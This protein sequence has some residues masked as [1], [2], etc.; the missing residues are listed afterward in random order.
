MGVIWG[1]SPA[2]LVP[3]GSTTLVTCQGKKGQGGSWTTWSS[4]WKDRRSKLHTRGKMFTLGVTS[5]VRHLG[6]STLVIFWGLLFL[7]ISVYLPTNIYKFEAESMR[8]GI[9]WTVS[10]SSSHLSFCSAFSSFFSV[11]PSSHFP[12]P[13]LFFPVYPSPL[14]AHHP[15][16]SHTNDFLMSLPLSPLDASELSQLYA[17]QSLR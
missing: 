9:C 8:A 4:T 15:L 10:H 16:H 3:R 17:T 13:S 1:Y 2:C 12:L 14:S 11:F 6:F 7:L 5:L